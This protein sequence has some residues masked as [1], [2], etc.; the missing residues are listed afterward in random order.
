MC[1][2]VRVLAAVLGMIERAGA[3]GLE[4]IPRG[5]Y[6]AAV[7][8]LPDKTQPYVSAGSTHSMSIM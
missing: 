4:L 8:A 1:A 7:A 5:N 3:Q 6:S 2:N